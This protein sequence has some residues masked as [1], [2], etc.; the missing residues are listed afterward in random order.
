ML[1]ITYTVCF[2]QPGAKLVIDVAGIRISSNQYG[3]SRTPW[4]N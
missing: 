1:L 2:G 3:V 4:E